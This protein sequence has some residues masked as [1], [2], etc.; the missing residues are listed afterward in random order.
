VEDI[1]VT[2][3]DLFR[4]VFLQIPNCA[5]EAQPLLLVH[6]PTLSLAH[7]HLLAQLCFENL[8]VTG[9]K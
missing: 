3:E 4:H 6:S 5:P 7:K 1:L 2:L 8:G 9:T